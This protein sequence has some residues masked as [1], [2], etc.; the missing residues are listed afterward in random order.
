MSDLDATVDVDAT[1]D[2]RGVRHLGHR[3]FVGGDGEFWDRVG[4]LQFRYLVEH[5]LRPTDVLLDLACG[6][7]RGGVRFIPYLERGHYLGFDRSIDLI[8]LGVARELGADVFERQAPEFIVNGRFDLAGFTRPPD[9]ILAQSL[10]T[11]LS[12]DDSTRALAAVASIA[13]PH[14]QFFLTFF[15]G[16]ARE[17]NPAASH[18]RLVFFYTMD[19][20]RRFG[21][22]SGWTLEHLGDWGHPRGQE[23]IRFT[24][25]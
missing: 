1:D 7:L 12:A 15:P 22:A 4:E 8:I 19:E 6:S 2:A 10:F 9:F 16:D 17:K 20:M 21:A 5:G 25:R 3:A 24:R 18:S 14:A 11:H 23:M 13:P